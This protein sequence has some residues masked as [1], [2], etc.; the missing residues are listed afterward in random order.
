MR[1]S[2]ADPTQHIRKNDAM[3]AS[4]LARQPNPLPNPFRPGNGVPPPY[5]AGRDPVLAAFEDWLRENP[6]LHANWALTGLPPS[7]RPP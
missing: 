5:L 1:R 4:A 2:P 7:G 3:N 6:P